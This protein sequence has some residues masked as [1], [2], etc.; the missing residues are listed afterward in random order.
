MT[1]SSGKAALV[2]DLYALYA[3][4]TGLFDHMVEAGGLDPATDFRDR[5]LRTML[6]RGADLAG[7][8]FS[9]S[10]LVGTAIRRARRVD[11]STKLDG[12]LLD[13]LDQAWLARRLDGEGRSRPAPAVLLSPVN[14]PFA[15]GA[16]TFPPLLAGRADIIER[17]EVSFQRL[18]QGRP[19]R[20]LI[21]TGLR[22][23]GKTVLLSAIQAVAERDHMIVV[24]LESIGERSLP[25][26]LVPPLRQTLLALSEGA[27]NKMDVE[28]A[29]SALASIAELTSLD[30]EL[31][32]EI[33]GLT[34]PELADDSD[35][36]FDLS[37]LFSTLGDIAE[38][39]G[40]GFVLIIDEMQYLADKQLAALMAALHQRSQKA[41]P[42]MIVGAGLPI[43]LGKIG[44]VMSYGERQFEFIHIGP[45]DEVAT[46]DAV[47]GPLVKEGVLIEPDGL[48]AIY[49]HTE[50]YP[51]FIQEWALH[52]WNEAKVSPI[53]REH[54]E[55][56][57]TAALAHL[58]ENFFRMRFDRLTPSE[59]RYLRA[60]AELGPGPHQS[61][62]V[63]GVLNSKVVG[64]GPVRGSL[65]RKGMIYSPTHG[66]TAFT[67]PLFDDFIR[68]AMP[69]L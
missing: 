51:Y 45:L 9:R 16:G 17:V 1:G 24:R 26:A 50:G 58:D 61:Q 63:A 53:T 54:V 67:V 40:S 39:R 4:P 21:L 52:S 27:P 66:E 25:G 59:M 31:S 47:L 15:P 11:A 48:A 5:D 19:V 65:I 30:E 28:K 13:E 2:E 46:N 29:L 20:S 12:A 33:S 68:R 57:T 60:M 41:R 56:A 34:T 38:K 14:N 62:D 10:N 6:F 69:S 35:L 32:G 43:L 37:D 7:F 49:A 44:S 22:G 42:V 55:R 18:R 8:D 3:E 36:Y 64:L 23:V